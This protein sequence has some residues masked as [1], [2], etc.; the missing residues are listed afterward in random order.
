VISLYRGAYS[1]LRVCFSPIFWARY[2]AIA[3]P[4]ESQRRAKPIGLLRTISIRNVVA[5]MIAV[6][7]HP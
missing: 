2:Q 4:D 3:V 5:D 6:F 1:T 7:K